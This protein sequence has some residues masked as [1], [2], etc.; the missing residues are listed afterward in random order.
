MACD[1]NH[2]VGLHELHEWMNRKKEAIGKLSVQLNDAR[3]DMA[4]RQVWHTGL[5]HEQAMVYGCHV[6]GHM[7]ADEVI[8]VMKRKESPR[9][10]NRP[11]KKRYNV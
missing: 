2:Q 3:L 11:T 10:A 1:Q 5:N 4:Y 6:D 9:R 7:G 8:E